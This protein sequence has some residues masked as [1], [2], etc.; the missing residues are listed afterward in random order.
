MNWK[1]SK[2]PH[3]TNK[4]KDPPTN[5]INSPEYNNKTSDEISNNDDRTANNDAIEHR[6]RRGGRIPRV[7]AGDMGFHLNLNAQMALTHHLMRR[8]HGLMPVATDTISLTVGNFY[9][10]P[11]TPGNSTRTYTHQL[12]A[13]MISCRKNPSTSCACWHRPRGLGSV[14]PGLLA[15]DARS[16]PTSSW[17]ALET[18]VTLARRGSGRRPSGGAVAVADADQG[19]DL[20]LHPPLQVSPRHR[21]V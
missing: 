21:P 4:A 6:G 15:G 17:W 12:S 20:A 16:P 10:A 8:S 9:D 14:E 13:E 2:H 3:K 7:R 18:L 5:P 11:L 1:N 19:G